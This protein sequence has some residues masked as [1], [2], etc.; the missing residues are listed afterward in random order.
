[1]QMTRR[2]LIK[3]SAALAA[4]SA[5]G[6]ELPL[7]KELQAVHA[8]KWVKAVCRY[9]G[10]G[11][12]VYAGVS[13][14]KVVAVQGDKDNWNKG[15]LCVKGYYLPPILYAADRATSPMLKKDGKFVRI[16]WKEA[17]DL[18]V[19][20]FAD[21]IKKN[22]ANA[23]AFYGSGQAYT[24]ESYFMNKFFKGGLGTNNIDGNPRLCMASAA[25]GYVS[26]FGKDEPMGS[27]DDIN[28]AD[29]FF[30]IGSNMAE[31]HPVIFRLVNERKNKDKN[32]KIIMADPRKTLSARIADLH[33]SFTPGTDLAILHAMAHVIVKENLYS[34]D[35]VGN[36]LVFKTVKDDK[37]AK[38]TFEEYVKFLEEYTPEMAEK[39]SQCPKEE[40]IKAARW[41]AQSRATMSFW[42]MGLNQRTRGVWVNNLVHN[43]HLLTGQICRPGATSF[44]LTG[45]PNACGGIRDTGLLSHLLP[46]GRLIANEKDREDMEKFW[47]VPRGR[48]QPKPGPTAVDIFRGFNRGEIKAL[49]IACTNPGQSL[50]NLSPYRKGMESKDT[51]L[52]V[53]EAYHPTRTSELADL[54]LPAALWVEKDG[55]Y[56]QSERR[57]QYL[58]KA[59]EPQG[60][61]RPDLMV[62]VEFANK[63]FKALGREAEAKRLFNYKNTED[64]WN[65]IRQ[66]SKG[67]AYDF[68]GMT[69]A[70]MKKAH[71]ILWPCPT[72]D[73]PGTLRRYTA[74]Y[75]DPLLKKF[76]PNA[77]DVSFYGA[78]ADGNK[79]TVWLRPYKGPAEPP[80]AEY[81]FVLTTG[82]QIE[83]WHTGTMTLKVP[84]LK[85]SAPD[86][87]VEINPKDAQKL[88]IKSRD[89]VR[90]T[91]RRGSI[92]LEAKVVD[93]PRQGL[94][95]VP[96]HYPDRLINIL[97]TDAYDAQSKQ[98]EF[99]ICAVKVEKV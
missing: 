63:L 82:R 23:V 30:I 6:L 61:A 48:I 62:M 32:V 72:E 33:M 38:V 89:K 60:E 91:S 97:T 90:L 85:R 71:G 88:G 75:G 95:F 17:M 3:Y 65:E 78:K 81:P 93:V 44:S 11:C 16:S 21:A 86:A 34:K 14:G 15:F 99:K 69:R 8:E 41:F 73:H 55:T 70:R 43:L 58:E 10:A 76:D 68:M 74:K 37:P 39:V 26:T 47:G 87:Y 45:Q 80:D 92:V 54:V 24:E 36:H 9:C 40:I 57:Y 28:H 52:V 98:P 94:V 29:C 59:V 50:P 46:Y 22:G 79:A 25:V 7:P 96:M 27:Y 5:I 2:Q 83:H 4:A 31:A 66:C 64:V 42:C 18:M 67:T 19:E 51:F 53:S 35:Y 13:K 49:W 12:G 1:M 20:K 84:E 56:G 77:K